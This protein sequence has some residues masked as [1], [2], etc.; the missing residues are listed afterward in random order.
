MARRKTTPERAGVKAVISER[1]RAARVA[2]YGERGGQELA[3]QL[4]ISL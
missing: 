1:L 3:R 2:L 4:E